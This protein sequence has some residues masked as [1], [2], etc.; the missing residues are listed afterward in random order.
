MKTI[1]WHRNAEEKA[2]FG[3]GPWAEEPD[4]VQW[5]DA[6]T[7]FACLVLRNHVGVWCGYVGVPEG[8][9]WHGK[10]Y[11]DLYDDTEVHGG[12]TFSDKCKPST[13]EA[14]GI[15]HQRED[16]DP[17]VWWL[18]FDCAHSMDL[19]PGMPGLGFDGCTYKSLDYVKAQCAALAA[20]AHAA[21]EAR[22]G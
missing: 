14:Y 15:C 16:G 2:R 8:H 12:L 5:R 4:K 9:P 21:K 1:I 10:P 7:G 6:T 18:G 3:P 11:D 17:E 22:L 13:D 19:V 20:Q